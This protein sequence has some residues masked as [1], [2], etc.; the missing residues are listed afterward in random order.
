MQRSV[1]N[2]MEK[3]PYGRSPRRSTSW[4][5]IWSK[6]R[7]P[8]AS[9]YKLLDCQVWS[10]NLDSTIKIILLA[11]FLA[12]THQNPY[13]DNHLSGQILHYK[14]RTKYLQN[15]FSTFIF[16]EY[17]VW[18]LTFGRQGCTF[19]HYVNLGL[20]FLF[21]WKSFRYCFVLYSKIVEVGV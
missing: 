19:L 2:R 10:W 17:C 11:F 13:E 21:H 15:L 12:T 14:S 18:C 7:W 3:T 16:T 20:R 8:T 1:K 9:F 6:P 4:S 5:Y